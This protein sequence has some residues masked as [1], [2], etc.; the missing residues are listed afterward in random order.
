MHANGEVGHFGTVRKTIIYLW[1]TWCNNCRN[2]S[3]FAKVVPVYR[4][5]IMDH[6]VYSI[7]NVTL[8]EV[9]SI[10]HDQSQPDRSTTVIH[11]IFIKNND[12]TQKKL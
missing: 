8:K 12:K 9:A 2:L 10:V 4:H 7:R 11:K 6:S 3:R 1:I 5:V